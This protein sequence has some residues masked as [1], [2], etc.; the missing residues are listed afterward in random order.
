MIDRP[1][2]LTRWVRVNWPVIILAFAVLGLVLLAAAVAYIVSLIVVN[3][4]I[5]LATAGLAGVLYLVLREVNRFSER[6]AGLT[7]DVRRIQQ[8]LRQAQVDSA[9]TAG[10]GLVTGL[11]S[12]ALS[13]GFSDLTMQL[14]LSI[15]FPGMALGLAVA[16]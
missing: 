3:V 7:S 8:E 4:W 14:F 6:L 12:F 10:L 13:S 5:V 11:T 1:T 16:G 2:R 15:W 9:L